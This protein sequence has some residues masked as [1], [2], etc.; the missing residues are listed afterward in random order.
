M[1][2]HVIEISE[3]QGVYQ[4]H[5]NQ[6]AEKSDVVEFIDNCRKNGWK[7]A[8]LHKLDGTVD[9]KATLDD[10]QTVKR[11]RGYWTPSKTSS[12]YGFKQKKQRKSSLKERVSDTSGK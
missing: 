7:F 5:I 12:H 3:S 10:G 6:E 1:G 9:I 2:M 4:E 8:N 11:M